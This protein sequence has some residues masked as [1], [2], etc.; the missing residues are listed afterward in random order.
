MQVCFR[1]AIDLDRA[2]LLPLDRPMPCL[3]RTGI[4]APL[5]PGDGKVDLVDWH[6]I[7]SLALLPATGT[8]PPLLSLPGFLSANLHTSC[9]VVGIDAWFGYL[10]CSYLWWQGD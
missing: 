1:L 7:T 6:A 4:V 3:R 5:R 10:A 9:R 2:V 8:V